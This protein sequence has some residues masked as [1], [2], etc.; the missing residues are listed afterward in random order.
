MAA[1]PGHVGGTRKNLQDG[2]S[3]A[4]ERI[5]GAIQLT[6]RSPIAKSV[7]LELLGEFETF[8]RTIF[9]NEV[10][11]YYTEILGKMGGAPPHDKAVMATCW[12][13]MTKLLK[14]LFKEIHKVHMFAGEL[15]NVKD[16]PAR[17]NSLFLYAALEELQV[18]REF[19]L[20]DHHSHPKYNQMVVLHLFDTS[21]PRAVYEKGLIGLGHDGL[22]FTRIENTLN[23][24]KLSIDMLDTAV[25]SLR[26]HLQLPPAGAR[27]HRSGGANSP[28]VPG[29]TELK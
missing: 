7:I 21:L 19:E 12:A 1:P 14:V 17:V 11:N 5:W 25:G 10:G 22:R 20:Y 15:G 4:F 29:V 6:L 23:E 24:H 3:R 18:L 2:V 13:L 9:L 26:S 8:F 16:D 28:T 27:R